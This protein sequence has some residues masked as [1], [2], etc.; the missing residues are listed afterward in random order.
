MSTFKQPTSIRRAKSEFLCQRNFHNYIKEK[1]I[2]VICNIPLRNHFVSDGKNPSLY[3]ITLY[4][5]TMIV[6]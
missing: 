3:A 4:I 2:F 6:S 1:L 5:S